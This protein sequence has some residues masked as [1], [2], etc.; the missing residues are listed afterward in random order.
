MIRLTKK[1]LKSNSP[2]NNC[3]RSSGMDLSIKMENLLTHLP[4][5]K[6]R[7]LLNN[8][9]MFLMSKL[10][11]KQLCLCQMMIDILNHHS[12]KMNKMLDYTKKEIIKKSQLLPWIKSINLMAWF[13]KMERLMIHQT[14]KKLS[15]MI[16]IFKSDPE[17]QFQNHMMINISKN[18]TRLMSSHKKSK[19]KNLPNQ[20]SK[21]MLKLSTNSMVWS[22]RMERHTT[23]L[24]CKKLFQ[25][26]MI[27]IIFNWE[28]QCL[29][30]RMTDGMI[31]QS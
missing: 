21:S 31:K 12:N 29:K 5:I 25:I 1:S 28:D 15:Q 20:K 7:M 16:L 4:F 8:L 26:L 14:C 2:R 18:P 23:H 9:M 30:L 11:K 19:H 22:I 3:L 24:T 10:I 27:S 13:I 17:V 6:L